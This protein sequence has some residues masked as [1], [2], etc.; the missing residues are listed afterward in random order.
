MF[1]NIGWNGVIHEKYSTLRLSDSKYDTQ[2]FEVVKIMIDNK[3]EIN[4]TRIR[5][6]ETFIYEFEKLKE[7]YPEEFIPLDFIL[8]HLGKANRDYHETEGCNCF[9]L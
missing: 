6:K 5:D 7:F 4:P 8:I 1:I 2:L 3:D 9:I